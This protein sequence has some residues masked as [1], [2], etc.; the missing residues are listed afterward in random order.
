MRAEQE[1]DDQLV[2]RLGC[3]LLPDKVSP[4]LINDGL[5]IGGYSSNSGNMIL[6]WYDWGSWMIR[7][8]YMSLFEDFEHHLQIFV[9]GSPPAR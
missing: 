8:W 4:G 1:G 7:G 2:Q 5:L 9:G 6:E 3:S